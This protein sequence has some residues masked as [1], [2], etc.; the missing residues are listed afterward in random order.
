MHEVA[1]RG[2]SDK[3]GGVVGVEFLLASL[4]NR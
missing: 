2:G 1:F 3:S 4:A